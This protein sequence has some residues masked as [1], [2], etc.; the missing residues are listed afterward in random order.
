M[1]DQL[2]DGARDLRSTS[3]EARRARLET[4]FRGLDGRRF[5]LSEILP[6]LDAESLAGYRADCRARGAL[7]LVLKRRDGRYVAGSQADDWLLLLRDPLEADLVL[8]YLHHRA[9]ARTSVGAEATFG[10][11]RDRD[12]GPE[13]VPVAKAKLTRAHDPDGALDKWISGHATKRF[14]PVT[15]VAQGL[16]ARLAFDA[17]E[18]ARRRKAGLF[19]RAPE[20]VSIA[21]EEPVDI[22]ARL[23]FLESCLDRT[24]VM[25]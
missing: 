8:M 18:P 12:G 19:L 2:I 9:G 5:S 23:E 17:V 3:L 6:V 10:A 11:W 24:R 1:L 7:G 4:V 20:V 16:V 14:G 13:L 25:E 21:W 15:E 22:A